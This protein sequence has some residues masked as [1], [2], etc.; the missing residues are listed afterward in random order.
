MGSAT[1]EQEIPGDTRKQVKE[2][3]VQASKQH[4]F[5]VSASVLAFSLLLSDGL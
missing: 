2:V 5:I 3:R 1:S 4:Y